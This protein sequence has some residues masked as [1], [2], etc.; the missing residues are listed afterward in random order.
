MAGSAFTVADT[1]AMEA[2]ATKTASGL[3]EL[4][5]H[6]NGLAG[7]QSAFESAYQG[8]T[9]IAIQQQ[10]T[11]TLATGKDLAGFLQWFLDNL[12]AAHV[13]FA[14]HDLEQ[15]GLVAGAG[16]DGLSSEVSGGL[17]TASKVDLSSI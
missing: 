11:S 9:G 5:A 13:K 4:Q 7:C 3:G 2:A 8:Q 6:L 12:K 14:E 1:P 17:P 10:Y 15:K 16:E